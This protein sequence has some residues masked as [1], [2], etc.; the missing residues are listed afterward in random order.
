MDALDR[1]GIICLV[2]SALVVLPF[3]VIIGVL[4][5]DWLLGGLITIVALP[6]LWIAGL[7]ASE[8]LTKPFAEKKIKGVLSWIIAIVISGV[9]YIVFAVLLYVLFRFLQLM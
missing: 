6:L 2:F 7:N 9:V 4:Q 3:L 8:F 5:G 1:L